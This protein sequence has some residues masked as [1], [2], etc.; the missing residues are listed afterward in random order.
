MK[1]IDNETEEGKSWQ[2]VYL[3]VI[4]FLVLQILTYYAFTQYFK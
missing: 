4:L 1:D 3:F 2:N